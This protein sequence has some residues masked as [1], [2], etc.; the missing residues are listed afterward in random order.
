MPEL[1]PLTQK[2]IKELSRSSEGVNVKRDVI[3]KTLYFF[4]EK[5][6]SLT[7]QSFLE[8]MGCSTKKEEKLQKIIDKCLYIIKNL[9]PNATG[10]REV[11]IAWI[12][13]V[14]SCEIE[15][16]FKGEDPFLFYFFNSIKKTIEINKEIENR[17]L[18]LY[19]SI[20]KTIFNFDNSLIAYHLLKLKYNNWENYTTEDIENITPQIYKE[21]R[22][23]SSLLNSFHLRKIN[24]I[25]KQRKLSFLVLKEVL[26]KNDKDLLSNPEHVEKETI[27]YYEKYLDKAKNNTLKLVTFFALFALTTKIVLLLFLEIPLF[28]FN[29]FTASLTGLLPTILIAML[30]V[31]V[32]SPSLKNRKKLVLQIIRILYKKEEEP[33]IINLPKERKNS[34]LLIDGFYLFGFLLLFF[35]LVWSFTFILPLLSSFI[36]VF[37]I[38]IVAF[39]DVLI[40]EKMKELF[41][42]EKKENFLNIVVDMLAFPLIKIKNWINI[43]RER[44]IKKKRR[45]NIKNKISFSFNYNFDI[46]SYYK[47]TKKY[48]R[49]KKENIYKT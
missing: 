35:L 23:I 12:L 2:L 13:S 18:L 30:S 9:P 38:L 45:K 1:S 43:E 4:I 44:E 14:A 11:F 46:S 21:R 22:E 41:V 7:T 48:L 16:F 29:D 39:L 8:K 20:Q 32:K 31:K 28:G 42:I 49:E 5:D 34:Y 24:R 47:K 6:I 10:S 15:E 26:K 33:V 27:S 3:K 37:Y 19:V 36:L 25:C 17:D 40:R